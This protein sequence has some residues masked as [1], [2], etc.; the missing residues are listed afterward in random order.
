MYF[1]SPSGMNIPIGISREV[2]LYSDSVSEGN[3]AGTRPLYNL[4]TQT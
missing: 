4:D 2:E 1:L 3:S